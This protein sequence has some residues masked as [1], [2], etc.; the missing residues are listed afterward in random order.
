[1]LVNLGSVNFWGVDAR[2]RLTPIPMLELGG[3]YEY[4]K[5]RSTDAGGITHDDPLPRLPHNRWD[6]WAQA[7]PDPRFSG[8]VRVK[9]FGAAIDQS[10]RVAGYATLEANLAAQVT[11]QYL[12]VLNVDDLSNVQPETRVGYHTAGR[13]ISLIMQ[14]AWE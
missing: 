8:L 13:V 14:G 1:M 5:A 10:Q 9:Y 3:G 6:A 4:V 7:R 11:K 12:V 2:A